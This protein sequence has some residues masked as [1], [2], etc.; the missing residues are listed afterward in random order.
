[1]SALDELF[2]RFPE[3]KP[4]SR[5]PSLSTVNGIGTMV[6]GRRDYDPDTGTYVLT[7]WFTLIY[8]PIIPLAAYRVANAAGGGW[9]FLGRVPV[10]RA[11][12][13]WTGS[14]FLA[15]ACVA[16]FFIWSSHTG[17]ADYKA[18]ARLAE[19]D[20]LRDQGH[21]TLAA[22]AYREVAEGPT[23]HARTAMKSLTALLDNQQL[24]D[25]APPDELAGAFQVAL[26]LRERPGALK[27]ADLFARGLKV[28]EARAGENPAGSLTI[29]EAVEP[30]APSPEALL[31]AKEKV[32]T[33]VTAER[34][35][36]MEYLSKLAVV[37]EMMN[38]RD[39]LQPLL[40]PHVKDLGT[41]EGARILGMVYARQDKYDAAYALL[42]PY[43]DAHLKGFHDAIEKSEAASRAA[44]E[45]IFNDLNGKNATGFDYAGYQRSGK[46]AQD[47][48]VHDYVLGRLGSDP[49]LKRQQ[50]ALE[51]ES[52]VVPAALDLGLMQMR[53]AQQMID[54]K[55]RKTELERA[56]KTFLSVQRGA[57]G[58]NQYR[59]SLGQVYYWLGKREEGKKLFDEVLKD[60]G[61]DAE[62]LLHVASLLRTLGA[63]GESRS[64]SEE[65]YNKPGLDAAKR[66][67]AALLRGLTATDLDD[68]IT[69]LERSDQAEPTAKASLAKARGHKALRDGKDAEAA[70]QFRAG[71]AVYAAEPES[72]GTLN[73]AG[74]LCL[75]LYT[76]TGDREVLDQGV[77]KLEKA[78]KMRPDDG[79]LVGNVASAVMGAALREVL[80]DRI[81]LKKLKAEASLGHFA[82]LYRDPAGRDE[83]IRSLKASPRVARAR[84]H[85]ER[86]LV[87]APSNAALYYEQRSLLSF[88][89]DTEGL[90]NLARRA[91]EAS[92]DL[93]EARKQALEFYQG[94][95]DEKSRK[96]AAAAVERAERGLKDARAVG[97]TTLAVAATAL[98][99]ARLGQERLGGP[100][101]GDEVVRLAEE[102]H[103]TAPSLATAQT[104][105]VALLARAH[106]ALAEKEPA[107][108][109]MAQRARRSVASSYLI[110]VALWRPGPARTA[111]LANA[112]V[113]RVLESVRARAAAF[114]DDPGEWQWAMLLAA[115]PE[116][117]AKVAA[118]LKTSAANRSDLALDALLSPA[119]ATTALRLC[120]ARDSAA[121]VEAKTDVLEPLRK[122]AAEGVPV[123]FDVK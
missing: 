21:L 79:I 31:P 18:K 15:L 88:L 69:W 105:E 87:L 34:P 97:G 1:M 90:A 102:A 32:L 98:V 19:A 38:K 82:Y 20:R 109:A 77:Q 72:A 6:Y 94:K 52:G 56:E 66:Q 14:L 73:N 108:A 7:Q 78:V 116:D 55:A 50:A 118:A 85:F 23:D 8:V 28:A 106:K 33:R 96:D 93:S 100:V 64:L 25:Q 86:A 16:G 58:D 70:E 83:I 29:L 61:R 101:D 37:Y 123:P 114:P 113:K 60:T 110:A 84:G 13:G 120:W 62:S 107:Y 57:A 22:R 53:R 91:E 24:C 47:A 59:L 115:Y 54:P 121:N 74:L 99:Q 9:Y 71:L 45:R 117:A 68:T 43:M 27:P 65:A 63:A 89:N 67:T 92:P 41:T 122:C 46:A 39:L 81:D 119:S 95:T 11:A 2:A 111:A 12:K 30:A 36:D 3:M 75:E 76:V 42:Q 51:R 26:E 104:L 17:T 112:D 5:A 49:E 44:Q 10:S 40:E 80:A 35:D 103:K 4:V 48:M